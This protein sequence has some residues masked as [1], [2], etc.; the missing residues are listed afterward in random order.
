MVSMICPSLNASPCQ[1]KWEARSMGALVVREPTM[2]PRS[3]S[4]SA[5]R[6]AADNMPASATTTMPAM[7]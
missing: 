1:R 7:P 6:L 5:V 3:A 2:N 4:Y